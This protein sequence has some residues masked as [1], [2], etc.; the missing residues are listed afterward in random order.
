ME[1]VVGRD[2]DQSLIGKDRSVEEDE[3]PMLGDV[4]GRDESGEPGQSRPK[5]CT[6]F[7]ENPPA[8]PVRRP[9]H[10]IPPRLDLAQEVFIIVYRAIGSYRG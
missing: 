7:A 5:A 9:A 2:G 1:R 3:R 4:R 6:R 8:V 10:Q